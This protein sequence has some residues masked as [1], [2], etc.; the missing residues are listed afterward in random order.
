MKRV[1]GIFMVLALLVGGIV[2]VAVAQVN[3][4]SSGSDP[5]SWYR[6]KE[7]EF[8]EDFSEV[9]V[10]GNTYPVHSIL[11]REQ[12]GA[13]TFWHWWGDY[14]LSMWQVRFTPD[15]W[16]EEHV[17]PMVRESIQRIA[18][19]YPN[20]EIVL[21]DGRP[22][23]E[24]EWA[25]EYLAHL[26]AKVKEAAKDPTINGW[27]KEAVELGVQAQQLRQ[28]LRAEIPVRVYRY[29]LYRN[30]DDFIADGATFE[31]G[32]RSEEVISV[33]AGLFLGDNAGAGEGTDPDEGS[34]TDAP[35]M[36]KRIRMVMRLDDPQVQVTN[37]VGTPYE[38][39]GNLV[40]DQ[41]PMAPNGHTLIP[42]RAFAETF[43][44]GVQWDDQ[45]RTAILTQGVM[46][47]QLPVGSNQVTVTT[48]GRNTVTK[49]V[50][51]AEPVRIENNRTLIPLRFVSETFGYEV[52]WD[53]TLREITIEG[54]VTLV[55]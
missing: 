33:A 11:Y 20:E 48:H 17:I 25:D 37:F 8:S 23:Q 5:L 38:Y 46:E 24:S 39:T 53:G 12:D 22:W 42:V 21:I 28:M 44:I 15:E 36:S 13:Y 18:S 27:L 16:Y 6:Y 10:G 52:G 34:S 1:L 29:R 54:D 30:Q 26:P 40:L 49:T 41:P 45:T 9:T 32:S 55:Y 7:W 35:L 50:T 14:L 3:V 19:N 43:S 4:A 51:I 31:V 47:I 2:P